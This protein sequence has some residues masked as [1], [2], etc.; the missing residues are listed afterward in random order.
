MNFIFILYFIIFFSLSFLYEM[1][2]FVLIS[3]TL[4]ISILCVSY[5]PTS[6][7]PFHYISRDTWFVSLT[8]AKSVSCT[9][10]HREG[11]G[12]APAGLWR[13][14]HTAASPCPPQ[15]WP[16]SSRRCPSWRCSTHLRDINISL[17]S[18]HHERF[19]RQHKRNLWQS[20]EYLMKR[21]TINKSEGRKAYLIASKAL[22]VMY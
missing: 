5:F 8:G 20:I 17:L 13:W 14:C 6:L 12:P 10:T 18:F 2:D 9:Q 16:A 11:T 21:T 3:T 22:N 4:N 19:R 7:E 1:I 15:V